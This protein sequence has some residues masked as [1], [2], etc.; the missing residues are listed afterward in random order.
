MLPHSKP[1]DQ[2]KIQRLKHD[3]QNPPNIIIGFATLLKE[4]QVGV[5]ND[6]QRRYLDNIL[7][8]AHSLSNMLKSTDERSD[9]DNPPRVRSQEIQN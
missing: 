8:S 3:L 9:N 6:K 4:E 7:S 5:L 1:P 2:S